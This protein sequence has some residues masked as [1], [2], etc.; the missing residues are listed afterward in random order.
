MIARAN[1][2]EKL[3]EKDALALAE[4]VSEIH[5]T[6]G[7]KVLRLD[8][9]KGNPAPAE[10]LAMMLGPAGNLRAPVIRK[11]RTLIVGF[12]EETYSRVLK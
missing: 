5:A 10:I 12:D 1:A 4:E 7:K 11:G 9:R 3:G 6:K 2:R 8:L